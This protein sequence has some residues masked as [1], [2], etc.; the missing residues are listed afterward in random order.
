MAGFLVITW[1][2]LLLFGHM[3]SSPAYFNSTGRRLT[4]TSW[5]GASVCEGLLGEAAP[6]TG[7][8]TETQLARQGGSPGPT[9][10]RCFRQQCQRQGGHNH[11]HFVL[12]SP[13]VNCSFQVVCVFDL[14]VLQPPC[15]IPGHCSHMDIFLEEVD[16]VFCCPI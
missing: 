14:D 8:A 10:R 5:E 13:F 16:K 7:H 15:Q 11:G 9:W 6:Q 12:D 4:N 2:I 3:S 1:Q